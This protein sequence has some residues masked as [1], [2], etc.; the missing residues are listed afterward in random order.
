MAARIVVFGATG[1]TGRLVVEALV[2]R[3]VRPV[4]AARGADKLAKLAADHG[5]LETAIA[6]VT[7]PE[8]VRSLVS[9]GDVLVTTVGPFSR[10]GTPAIEAALA[11][12]A[13][14]VDSAGEAAFIREVF[15]S[16][17]PRAESSALLTAFGYDYVPGNVAGALALQ[18]AGADARRVDIGY[19]MTGAARMSSGTRATV[20]AQALTP[21]HGFRGGRIVDEPAMRRVQSFDVVGKTLSGGSIGGTEQFALPRFAP[22]VD[23]VGIYLGWFGSAVRAAQASSYVMPLLNRVPGV[24]SLLA[25]PGERALQKTGEGPDEDLRARGG[26]RIVAVARDGSGRELA[27]ARLEGIDAYTLTGRLMAW[28][29]ERLAAGDASGAGALGPVDAFGLDAMTEC[30]RRAGLTTVEVTGG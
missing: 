3:G 24:R 29:A 17:G 30:V 19:F 1:Y 9:A 28:A 13:H 11:V 7:R 26:S 4:L 20:M 25:L 10:F 8:T 22:Q 12:G 5:D 14:Y 27:T 15:T 16:W 2:E 6:D 18:A 21:H 23:E